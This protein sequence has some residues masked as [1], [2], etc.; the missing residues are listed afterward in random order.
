MAAKNKKTKKHPKKQPAKSKKSPQRQQLETVAPKAEAAVQPARPKNATA[1]RSSASLLPKS[2]SARIVAIVLLVIIGVLIVFAA[3]SG[4]P[5]EVQTTSSHE[6]EELRVKVVG[7][8]DG[9]LSSTNPANQPSTQGLNALQ[10]QTNPTQGSSQNLQPV[11]TTNLQAGST[12]DTNAL[13]VNQ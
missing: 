12:P 1:T 6:G 13:N 8:D 11:P 7:E 2:P 3:N 5:K 10:S 4:Q 9:D